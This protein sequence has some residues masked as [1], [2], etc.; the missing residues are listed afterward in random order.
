M[1]VTAKYME[2]IKVIVTQILEIDPREMTESSLFKEDHQA[3]SLRAIEI[4][5]AL[6][7][8]FGVDIPQEDLAKMVNLAG[9]YD[10]VK[11]H[12]HWNQ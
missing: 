8:E 6:E 7:Q 12:A 1:A 4:M 9:V 2:R 10:V 3:D 5:A 11:S